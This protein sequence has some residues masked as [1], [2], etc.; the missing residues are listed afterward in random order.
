MFRIIA[1]NL[2]LEG[3]VTGFSKKKKY[4]IP[5]TISAGYM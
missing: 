5:W 3:G 4:N 2:A 1:Y